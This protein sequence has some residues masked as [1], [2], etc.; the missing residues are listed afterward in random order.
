[1][2]STLTMS[3]IITSIFLPFL[4]LGQKFGSP[5]SDLPPTWNQNRQWSTY[6]TVSVHSK[7]IANLQSDTRD[8][9]YEDRNCGLVSIMCHD[10]FPR[11][12]IL[13]SSCLHKPAQSWPHLLR[14]WIP[15]QRLSASRYWPSVVLTFSKYQHFQV[16]DPFLCI[17]SRTPVRQYPYFRHHYAG[18]KVTSVLFDDAVN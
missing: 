1:M 10:L 11:L 2:V 4:L 3:I 14:S 12:H 13:R 17:I 9:E 6:F 5:W 18:C 8:T 7:Y 15:S 16:E